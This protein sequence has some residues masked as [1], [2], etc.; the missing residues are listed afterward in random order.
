[1]NLLSY[2]NDNFINLP[3]GIRPQGVK[4][5]LQNL[6]ETP[7][8]QSPWGLILWGDWLAGVWYPLSQSSSGSDT[9]ESQFFSN[10]KFEYLRKILNKIENMLLVR[11]PER[12]KY[13]KKVEVENLAYDFPF[14]WVQQ[15]VLFRKYWL[16]LENLLLKFSPHSDGP[17]CTTAGITSGTDKNIKKEITN[18][19]TKY[20]K[21]V[22]FKLEIL[23]PAAPL[24]IREKLQ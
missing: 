17:F 5:I 24:M 14:K 8:S 19:I 21:I 18:D 13:G 10:V 11:G 2:S 15:V 3:W 4:R 22:F 16:D 20:S 7:A 1:M 23:C 6:N 9:L 12:F